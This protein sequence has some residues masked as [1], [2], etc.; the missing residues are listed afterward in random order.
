M[1]KKSIALYL[2]SVI[3]IAGIYSQNDDSKNFTAKS[4]LIVNSKQKNPLTPKKITILKKA[5]PDLIF[6]LAYNE[7]Y[8]DW[9]LK[10]TDP[11]RKVS[12]IFYWNDGS[13]IPESE[14]VNKDK[15]WTILYAYNKELK[16]PI[17]MTKEEKENLIHYSSAENRKN[18]SGTPMFFFDF[19][20]D[21]YSQKSVENHIIQTTFLG[22]KTRIHKRIIPKI[23]TVEKRIYETA[24]EDVEVQQFLAN[25]QS[26]DAY[27][28]RRIAGT[29][30]KSFHSLGIAIDIL[31]NRYKGE[32]FWSWTKDKD[33]DGWMLTPLSRRWMPPKKVIQIF[34]EEGFVWG[35]KWAIWDNM[36][37]E[38]HPELLMQ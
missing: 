16:D 15:Y 14:L 6:N 7:T 17:D 12:E 35:G 2:I 13:M 20:Y 25:I 30:R 33:P 27:F 9:E 11:E 36:H 23:Q 34:E 31:P 10:V 3:L 1:R 22:K 32:M 4:G 8:D 24:K 21:S 28:W 37:F 38:Y 29:N 18:G 5:Y 19:I 26:A